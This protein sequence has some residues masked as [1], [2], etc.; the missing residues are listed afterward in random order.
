M[1][2]ERL[3]LRHVRSRAPARVWEVPVPVTVPALGHAGLAAFT[4][5]LDEEA[6]PANT[7]IRIVLAGELVRLRVV[8]WNAEFVT[9]AQR[10]AFVR[11][12]FE[13]TY[14]PRAQGWTCCVSRE[15]WGAAALASA[16]DTALLDGLDALGKARHLPLVSVQPALMRAYQSV[17]QRLNTDAFWFVLV[18]PDAQVTMLL[19]HGGSVERVRVLNRTGSTEQ[20]V[21]RL[22]ESLDREWM[23]AGI[24]AEPCPVYLYRVGDA[25]V[26]DANAKPASI[27]RWS[28]TRVQGAGS[29]GAPGWQS[30]L[31]A[32]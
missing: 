17:R 2:R 10:A 32:A 16:I 24:D 22:A 26:A 30:L 18:E 11:Y 14:G 25:L 3:V 1:A 7:Q 27:G 21:A 15:S 23:A 28:V 31:E 8:P 5:V 6:L 13:D 19:Q 29:A 9:P 4:R 20:A 12:C